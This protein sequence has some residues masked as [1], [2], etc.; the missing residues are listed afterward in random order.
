MNKNLIK[1]IGVIIIVGV[2]GSVV[3]YTKLFLGLSK[4]KPEIVLA[5]ALRNIQKLK[6][7][8]HEENFKIEFFRN[9][10]SSVVEINVAGNVDN[11][12][13]E[14]PKASTSI[15]V[16]L[17]N[18]KEESMRIKGDLIRVGEEIFGKIEEIP[19]IPPM[20]MILSMIG[21][22]INKIENVWIKIDEKSLE[23][24]YKKRGIE[25]KKPFKQ[26]ELSEIFEGKKF[27]EFLILKIERDLGVEKIGQKKVYHYI[28]SVDKEKIKEFFYQ[29]LD[30]AIPSLKEKEEIE[31]EMIDQ[32]K[33]VWEKGLE[34][35]G[36]LDFEIWIGKE[37]KMIYKIAFDKE[38][39]ISE[40]TK[41]NVRVKISG[42]F[43]FSKFNEK[44]EI[45]KPSEFKTLEEIIVVP[46]WMENFF[47]FY[48]KKELKTP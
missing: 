45:V 8:H 27:K 9:K 46:D 19:R 14:V 22:D 28:V 42:D 17:S 4:E 2:I 21:I 18:K 3:V 5:E 44:I 38:I 12:N 24:F 39:D 11:K 7:F 13:K 31:I 32:I 1:I 6:T 25:V 10:E 35:I 23:N 47:Q 30:R 20:V 41:E 16:N 15:R 43:N 26:K 36:K 34:K 33:K 48:L 40:E 29:I 37:D